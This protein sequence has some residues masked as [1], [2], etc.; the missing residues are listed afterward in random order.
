MMFH[1]GRL[2]TKGRPLRSNKIPRGAW[3]GSSRKRLSSA[4]RCIS[5]PLTNC[6]HPMRKSSTKKATQR[7]RSMAEVRSL[8]VC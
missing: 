5:S 3:I 7:L 8:R 1:A 2:R 4:V 6:N